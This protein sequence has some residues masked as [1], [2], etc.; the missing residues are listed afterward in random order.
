MLG[1]QRAKLLGPSPQATKSVAVPAPQGGVNRVDGLAEMPP[2]DAV[3][4]YNMVPSEFGTRLRTGYS[5][6]STNVGSGGVRT[7]IPFTGATTGSNALFAAAEN[8]I[9]D[10]TTGGAV[11]T[12]KLTFGTADDTSGMGVWTNFVNDAAAYFCLYADET[13]GYH[14]YTSAT[15]T[16]AAVAMGG[17]ATQ[18]NGV[19]PNKF[20]FVT[21]F[22]NRVWFVERGT[23]N[24]WYLP[25]G[26]IYGTATL[27]NF[28]NKFKHGGTLV[29]LY[30]WTVDG[31]EGIDDYLVAIGSGGDVVVYKGSDPATATDWFLHGSWFIGPP[32]AGRRI[33]GS[34]SGELYILSSY[35]VLPM[36]KLMSGT[37]V[38]L[39]E[40][41]LSRK[42]TPLINTA[43]LGSRLEYGWEVR[44]IPTE[45][46]LIVSSPQLTGYPYTQ[47]AYSLNTPGWCVYQD[48]PY[49]TGDTWTGEF[50]FGD[51]TGRVYK[52]TGNQDSVLLDGSGGVDIAG[53]LLMNF[54][55]YG[56]DGVY[57]RVQFIRP[58]FLADA[59]PSYVVDARYDYNLSE[60]FGAPS[61]TV[62]SGALWD[63]ALWDVGVWTGEFSVVD[64][65][66]GGRGLGRV[67]SV[68]LQ[69]RAS[70]AT[71][72]IK[73][74]L[75]MDGGGLL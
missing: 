16:W 18:I 34:F 75:M 59:A 32:P 10:I 74:D 25:A 8:G 60:A 53:S 21:I 72:L 47:F 11:P 58:I 51:A 29:A 39:D 38:Q 20:A 52:H 50:Y 7:I 64:T 54:Q 46:I 12:L 69:L 44:L 62:I 14:V 55:G 42:I 65:V 36:S 48:L 13:N 1:Y 35:G 63:V 27:F 17:G 73:F 6:W 37:L 23:G 66:R 4:L 71:T 30:S 15:N 68:A 26:T 2:K 57:K 24:A 22:K 70:A 41:Y 9:Y 67:V 3:F 40:V 31:G 61:G 33:A 45:N 43:M 49:F 19:N 56:A 28:G 5:E